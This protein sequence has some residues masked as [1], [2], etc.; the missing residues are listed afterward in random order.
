MPLRILFLPPYTRSDT[1]IQ[2]A[3]S[4]SDGDSFSLLAMDKKT[5]EKLNFQS[6]SAFSENVRGRGCFFVGCE[7]RNCYQA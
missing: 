1:Q 4:E 2:N 7:S 5:G 6:A 3:F